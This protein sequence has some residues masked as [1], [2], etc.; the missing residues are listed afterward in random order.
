M[1]SSMPSKR[2][3]P[4]DSANQEALWRIEAWRKGDVLDLSGLGLKQMPPE[5]GQLTALMRLRLDSNQLTTLPPEIGQLT[6]LT[7]L[8]LHSNQ[9]TTLPPEIGQLP[10]L[11]QLSLSRNQLTTLPPE[12]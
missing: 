6:A 9:L 2:T 1:W 10:A 3:P 4:I 11:T 7:H 8:Y 5:I 12:I